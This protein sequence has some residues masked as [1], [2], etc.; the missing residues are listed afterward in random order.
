MAEKHNQIGPAPSVGQDVPIIEETLEG[1]ISSWNAAAAAL[2][3]YGEGEALG[4]SVGILHPEGL[5]AWR[6]LV[7]RVTEDGDS[8]PIRVVHRAKSGEQYNVTLDVAPKRNSAG[9]LEGFTT[10]VRHAIPAA[11]N[12]SIL[13][14][15]DEWL[16]QVVETAVDA[17]ITIDARGLI[18]YFNPAAQRLFGYTA[19]EA[20]GQ[21]VKMLMPSPYQEEHDGYIRSYLDSGVKHIIGIGREVVGRRK[22]GSV[23]PIHLSV[24]EARVDGKIFFTGIIHDISEQKRV[25]SEKDELLR[26]LDRRNKEI[27]CLLEV[28]RL[29]RTTEFEPVQLERIA[30]LVQSSLQHAEQA[31]VRITFDDHTYISAAYGETSTALEAPIRTQGKERGKIA[32]FYVAGYAETH[33]RLFIG[34][35]SRLLESIANTI[36]EAVER[37]EAEAKVIHASKLASIGELAAGVGHE[38]NNPINGIINCADILIQNLHADAKNRQFAEFVRSEADRIATIVRNLLTFSRQDREQHSMARLCDIVTAVLSLS[39]KKL[40]KSHIEIEVDV[41]EELPKVQC[42]SE[43]LQQVVM[44]LLINAMHAL[45]AKY[46]GKDSRKQIIIRGAPFMYGGE[47]WVRLS[48]EDHGPGIP[49]AHYD[50]IF[51]PFF[52]TKGRDKGTGLGLSIS[53]GIVEQHGGKM[54]VESEQGQY[55]R[56][57]VDLPIVEG[58]PGDSGGGE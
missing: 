45:D 32:A 49:A 28:S 41:P 12:S 21:N 43:Q 20:R 6:Q 4:Q 16:R 42:R 19:E 7:Q 36:G 31:R 57:H 14:H 52:T 48:V 33:P 9:V 5:E 29:L 17:I 35:E 54:S 23:F 58:A 2:Y 3:G 27:G 53:L 22:D 51:D 1:D 15:G 24:S 46:T 34:V 50:R 55:T 47:R 25:A 18:E 11:S 10:T 38:I 30:K 26:N 39:R 56:F 40:S 37:Q 13:S 8:A 44:N